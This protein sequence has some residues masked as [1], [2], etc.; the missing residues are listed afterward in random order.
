MQ[1]VTTIG[2]DIAKSVFQVH[3]V[4][5]HGK[6]VVRRQP[7]LASLKRSHKHLRTVAIDRDV[8]DSRYVGGRR[9]RGLATPSSERRNASDR[10]CRGLR[11]R[12]TYLLRRIRTND[13]LRYTPCSSIK[14][15]VRQ[16]G[17]LCA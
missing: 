11:P 13:Q 4:D 10:C 5:A 14:L 7:R 16:G 17:T 15:A 3:G 1:V 6:V 9:R 8:V 2:L 12:I